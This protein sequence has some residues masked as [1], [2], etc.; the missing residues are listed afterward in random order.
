MQT[1]D[2][3]IRG[4][5]QG[6]ERLRILARIL[7][8]A[9]TELFMRAGVRPGLRCLEVG[10]G[11]GDVAC[12]LAAMVGPH[13]HVV[14]TDI[15]DPQLHIAEREARERDLANVEFCLSDIT[16]EVPGG[17]FD[18]IHVRFVLT[19][20]ADPGAA[21]VRMRRALKPDG[22]II[23]QDIDF[24]GYFCHPECPSLWRH[25]DLYKKAAFSS[26]GD[27]FIG[28]K[29]PSILQSAG[30]LLLGMNVVQQAATEGELKLNAA[31]TMENIADTVVGLGM[32]TRDEANQITDD[33]LAYANRP[34]TVMSTP[35]IIE[36]WGKVA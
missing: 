30:F 17:F 5:T 35:R 22:V 23:I 9:T 16:R 32:A 10:C 13:G 25:V 26:G 6:R 29:L 34:D 33:L 20:L 11:G 2:Y 8:A 18:V 24:D 7:N 28:P 15:D 36:V 12:D 19:H 14:A 21:L 4:G 3:I 31:I 27:P 1:G